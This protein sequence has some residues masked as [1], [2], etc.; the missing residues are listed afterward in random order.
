MDPIWLIPSI[1]GVAA[2][3]AIIITWIVTRNRR[4]PAEE[5]DGALT[6]VLSRLDSLDDRLAKVEKTLSDIP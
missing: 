4:R 3:A 2:W 5:Q 1:I 6:Q